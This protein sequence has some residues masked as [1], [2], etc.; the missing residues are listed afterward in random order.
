MKPRFGPGGVEE[1]GF[2]QYQLGTDET[3]CVQV[4]GAHLFSLKGDVRGILNENHLGR[5]HT[6]ASTNVKLQDDHK[7]ERECVADRRDKQES[8]ESGH[9]SSLTVTSSRSNSDHRVSLRVT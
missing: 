3:R 2:H 1:E 7:R 9:I 5:P 6:R 4:R 8:R